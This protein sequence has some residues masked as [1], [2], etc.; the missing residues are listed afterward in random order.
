MSKSYAVAEEGRYKLLKQIL[1]K[2]VVRILLSVRAYVQLFVNYFYDFSRYSRASSMGEIAGNVDQ[3]DALITMNYHRLE[4]GLSLREPKPFFGKQVIEYLLRTI[5]YH[6][7]E[8]GSRES[9]ITALNTV[10]FYIQWHEKQEL[11]SEYIS[12]LKVDFANVISR[13]NNPSSHII[14]GGVNARVFRDHA[15]DQEI[16]FF[17]NE[18]HSVRHYSTE[19]VST[20][21]INKAVY[22]ATCT[23]SVC[24]RQSWR[25]KAFTES[26][27]I[28]HALKFQ[29][30][31][32]GFGHTVTVLFVVSVKLTTF[33]SPSERNQG[34]IDGG[35]FAMSLINALHALGIGSCPLNWSTDAKRDK[36]FRQAFGIPDD[37]V[38]IMF[39]AGGHYEENYSVCDSARIPVDNLL[40]IN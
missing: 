15:N 10:K 9:T 20:D 17:F 33:V 37:E 39:I 38:I 13:L 36:S 2:S 3:Y 24:N 30:G 6:Q 19:P 11:H 27:K 12:S 28:D 8:Y 26:S 4:K 35:M 40:T 31:N 18:R 1:P 34:W 14:K 21:I 25:V 22:L 29:N 7:R 16:N 23:P 32:R 5:E